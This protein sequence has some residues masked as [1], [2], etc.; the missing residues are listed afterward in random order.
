M[1]KSN[2]STLEDAFFLLCDQKSV[3]IIR[4]KIKSQVEDKEFSN[5]ETD[6]LPEKNRKIVDFSNLK[7]LLL[8][9]YI[10]VRENQIPLLLFFLFP[11]IEIALLKY[12]L[13]QMPSN[14]SIAIFNGEIRP[15]FSQ[16]FIDNIDREQIS[17][18]FYDTNE[19]AINSVFN[20]KNWFAI[21]F[22]NHFSE[23]FETK[24]LEPNEMTEEELDLSEIKL[25]ADLS[26][27]IIG[28]HIYRQLMISFEKFL[29][30]ISLKVSPNSKAVFQP[31]NLE[32]EFYGSKYSS[33]TGYFASSLLPSVLHVMPMFLV[34]L[35][36]VAERKYGHLERVFVAGVKPTE[37]LLT[38]IIM[39]FIAILLL[40]LISMIFAFFVFDIAM[41]GSYFDAFALLVCQSIQGMTFGQ[42][43]SLCFPDEFSVLVSFVNFSSSVLNNLLSFIN[44]ETIQ[45]ALNAFCFPLWFTSGCFWPLESV[46]Y[47]LRK[48]FYLNP[49]ALPVESMR[50]IMLRGWGI[51]NIN[52]LIGFIVSITYT[53]LI[54]V[55]N[56]VI[57]EKFSTSALSTRLLNKFNS[58][59]F[60]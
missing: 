56:F 22:A 32:E 21:T 41:N 4:D 50:S 46:P 19:T 55:T 3:E 8:K 42:F 57:I 35:V 30:N 43:L 13:G 48:L 52:V 60:E 54:T 11:I 45:T 34:A 5:I 2:A 37:V 18:K 49:L 15:N 29:Q 33:F 24:F 20:G 9:S 12:C 14:N 40:V 25:Y 38:N 31:I 17:T 36:F 23:S 58:K 26:N 44:I 51:D 1:Q 6:S 7:A 10:R 47:N 39:A 27:Y 28:N 53:L 16:I 59:I